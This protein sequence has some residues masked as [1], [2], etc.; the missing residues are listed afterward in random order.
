MK[1][2]ERPPSTALSPSRTGT[3]SYLTDTMGRA[4]PPLIV[5]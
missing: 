1:Q 3:R 5:S 4:E 2:K